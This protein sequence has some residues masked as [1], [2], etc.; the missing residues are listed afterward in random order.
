[1]VIIAIIKYWRNRNYRIFH[2]LLI[3]FRH[4]WVTE[5]A[6]SILTEPLLYTRIIQLRHQT[7]FFIKD[8]A[9]GSLQNGRYVI[10]YL[11]NITGFYGWNHILNIKMYF[12]HIKGQVSTHWHWVKRSRFHMSSVRFLISNVNYV[13]LSIPLDVILKNNISSLINDQKPV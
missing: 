11:S 7:F 8:I 13:R 2:I 1:M 3:Y 12:Y 5:E 6:T 4:Q 10:Y 9:K